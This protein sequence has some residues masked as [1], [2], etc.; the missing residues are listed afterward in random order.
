MC[1]IWGFAAVKLSFIV[2]YLKIFTQTWFRV[3]N[4][5]LAI[6]LTSICLEESLVLIFQCRPIR[7]AW[8]M[9]TPGYCVDLKAFYYASVRMRALD[10]TLG[11]R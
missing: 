6:L 2:L 11:P 3:V 9:T 10:P 1:Y 5:V 7:K 4:K 8:I